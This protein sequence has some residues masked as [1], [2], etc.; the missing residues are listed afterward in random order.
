MWS[1]LRLRRVGSFG[2]GSRWLSMCLHVF[3]CVCCLNDLGDLMKCVYE[4]VWAWVL[5]GPLITLE[6]Q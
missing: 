1:W 3:A 4:R 5:I 2:N 6:S